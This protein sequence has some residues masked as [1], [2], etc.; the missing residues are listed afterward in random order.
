MEV[1]GDI[2]ETPD[3]PVR[4]RLGV[5]KISACFKKKGLKIL[6]HRLETPVWRDYY[7]KIFLVPKTSSQ[8]F[9]FRFSLKCH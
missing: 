4:Q 1:G 2:S 6:V 7:A 3:I 9:F 8:D 5:S